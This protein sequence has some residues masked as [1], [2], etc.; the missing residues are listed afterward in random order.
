V[1]RLK[2][3]AKDIRQ[4][5]DNIVKQTFRFTALI[6]A[7]Y[8]FGV[9]AS[10]GENGFRPD[11]CGYQN[12]IL[13]PVVE[14]TSSESV[15]LSPDQSFLLIQD[16][17]ADSYEVYFLD[18]GRKKEFHKKTGDSVLIVNDQE[19]GFD[20]GG[21]AVAMN[22][23][24]GLKRRISSPS[25]TGHTILPETSETLNNGRVLSIRHLYANNFLVE[26]SPNDLA[27][28]EQFKRDALNG[29]YCGISMDKLSRTQQRL[30]TPLIKF[31][32]WDSLS[33]GR[34]DDYET[35]VKYKKLA[36]PFLDMP[37][38]D[39]ILEVYSYR[40]AEAAR[41]DPALSQ[42]DPNKVWSFAWAQVAELFDHKEFVRF[43]DLS[44][45]QRNGIITFGLLGTDSLEG[46]K[47]NK[48]GFYY[49]YLSKIA[50]NDIAP[51]QAIAWSWSQRDVQ[52]SANVVLNPPENKADV[53]VA[54]FPAGLNN[55]IVIFDKTLTSKDVKDDIAEY[56]KYFKSEGFEFA[57]R[58]SL[59]DVPDYLRRR[60]LERQRIDYLIREGHAD[61]D[62]DNL[63][64]I[65]A[66]GFVIEGVKTPDQTISIVFNL[67]EK[68]V[69][70]R[71][72]ND[73]FAG[74]VE[75]SHDAGNKPFVFLNT[76]CWGIEKAWVSLSR[77]SSSKLIEVAS[78]TPVNYF[79]NAQP[80]ATGI[81]INGIR[82]GE[83]F[84]SLRSKLKLL[85]D[86]GSGKGD[87]FVFPDEKEYPQMV[88]I[89]KFQR[90]LFARKGNGKL[91]PY[92]P[93]GYF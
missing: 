79:S 69:E 75:Q 86:Y 1:C 15:S 93:D 84:E 42:I 61:G 76:S 55:G 57:S 46:I 83:A 68:P 27:K 28:F 11:A 3:G 24:S 92:T 85:P 91:K 20:D 34:L 87:N 9:H 62:D 45:S 89:V 14:I 37:E 81:L 8:L 35:F 26:V 74:W 6:A 17:Y 10:L 38:L 4:F 18:N 23:Q 67:S 70:R 30:A 80:D 33:L 47:P 50:I 36:R 72:S 82:H 64:T 7:F 66:Q 32:W 21:S 71:I 22:V 39:D 54:S 43:T 16:K 2:R 77:L 88:P 44:V 90:S 58:K 5:K 56:L 13:G 49:K 25:P 19:L 78:L 60:F 65:Y 12:L 48:Y 31:L 41:S 29:S 73:Q 40:A 59:H 51:K 53:K 52:Y 63:V